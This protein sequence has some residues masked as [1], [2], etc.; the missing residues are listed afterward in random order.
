[1]TDPGAGTPDRGYGGRVKDVEVI[2]VRVEL[3]LNTPIVVLRELTGERH[4]PVW[5]GG[6]E[7]SAIV[8]GQQAVEPPRPLTHDLIKN[9]LT[10]L[11]RSVTRVE[12]TSV[13]ENIF[14]ARLVLDDG[15]TVEARTSDA[16]AI[17][18]RYGC[19]ILCA[20]EVLHS[21]GIVIASEDQD[22]VERFR[23]FLDNVSPDDFEADADS[24]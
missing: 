21:S 7:A 10:A 22:E 23:E 8:L 2:G 4:L 1:M 13:K 6:A 14:Y 12:I 18:L 16:I 5:I 17:A 3:P 15:S 11:G 24:E 19:S 9:I 20:D